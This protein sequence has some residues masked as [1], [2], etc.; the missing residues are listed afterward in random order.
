[1]RILFSKIALTA[2]AVNSALSMAFAGIPENCTEEIITLS[3]S[4]DFDMRKFKTNL[5][6]AVVKAKL[7]AKSPDKPNDN[8]KTN[9]G[10]T[11]GCVRAFPESPVEIAFL[12]KDISQKAVS[13]AATAAISQVQPQYVQPPQYA[14]PQ[15]VPPQEQPQYMQ[16]QAQPQYVQPPQYAQPQYAQPQ[17]AQPQV[18]YVY[19]PQ[20]CPQC[21]QCSQYQ[22]DQRKSYREVQRLIDDG[23]KKNKI[24]IQMESVY[25]SPADIENLYEKN[26]KSAGSSALL[27]ATIGLGIGSYMQGNIGM[28]VTQTLLDALTIVMLSTDAPETGIVFLSISRITGLIAPIVYANIYNESLKSALSLDN[29]S[30]SIDPLIVPKNG[31]PAVGLAFNLRY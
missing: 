1:M 26:K 19:L 20:P 29:I 30:Y 18:Q 7:M 16:P 24:E 25:L 21:P 27:G 3:K 23:V 17:Y 5:P 14:Q 11:F 15:Y 6:T 4:S 9:I 2:F 8:A 28:G 12:L 31:A 10:M 13:G 22:S